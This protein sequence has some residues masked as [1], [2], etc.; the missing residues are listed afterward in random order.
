MTMR[1]KTIINTLNK[2][3]EEWPDDLWIFAGGMGDSLV[4]MRCGENGEKVVTECGGFDPDRIVADF[5]IP[6]DGG[7]W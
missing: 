5:D 2:L 6:S 3:A 1:E 7:G 4:L